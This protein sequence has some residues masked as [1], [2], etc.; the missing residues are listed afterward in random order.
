MRV[1]IQKLSVAS[2]TGRNVFELIREGA[3]R[4][5]FAR[6]PIFGGSCI[7]KPLA[8][9]DSNIAGVPQAAR[10]IKKAKIGGH[11]DCHNLGYIVQKLEKFGQNYVSVD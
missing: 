2:E 9:E 5:V 11:K 7:P 4:K 1:L 6:D 3:K 8:L 10:K